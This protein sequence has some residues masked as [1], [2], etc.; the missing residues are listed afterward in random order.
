MVNDMN[1]KQR[2]KFM[3]V[4]MYDKRYTVET[5]I[6]QNQINAFTRLARMQRQLQ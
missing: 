4:L 1:K 6:L 5:Y 2:I 3:F